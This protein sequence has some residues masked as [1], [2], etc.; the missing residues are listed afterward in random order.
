[1]ARSEHYRTLQEKHAFEADLRDRQQAGKTL[2]EIAAEVGLSR[3]RV[4]QLLSEQD[5]REA[6]ETAAERRSRR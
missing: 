4:R 2:R 6:L 5:R 3:E 1:M